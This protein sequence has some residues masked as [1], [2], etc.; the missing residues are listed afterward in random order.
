M[1]VNLFVSVPKMSSSFGQNP[2]FLALFWSF[3]SLFFFVKPLLHKNNVL[4]SL[5][6]QMAIAVA[7][8]SPLDRNLV[9]KVSAAS[10]AKL[11]R[12]KSQL[13]DIRLVCIHM[14]QIARAA[15][16]HAASGG[17]CHAP[18]ININNAT[19]V[20]RAARAATVAL[21]LPSKMEIYR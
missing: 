5:Q 12:I 14:A 8:F 1:A 6:L 11:C 20:A 13:S 17:C 21:T 7:P 15:T 10:C 3:I 2:E 9:A 18:I 16:F 19:T 4:L